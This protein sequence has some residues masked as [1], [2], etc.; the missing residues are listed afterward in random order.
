[1]TY[2]TA[3]ILEAGEF[4]IR[5]HGFQERKYTKEP[6]VAH[7]FRV[8]ETVANV[9]NYDHDEE[10]IIAALL[11][12]TLEDTEATLEQ[13]ED[14]FGFR[15][16][17]MVYEL[18][19][20]PLSVGNRKFR[21][22]VDRSRLGGA[23]APVQTIKCADII[24]NTDSI[25]EHDPGFGKRFVEEVLLLLPWLQRADTKLHAEALKVVLD[26][27]KLLEVHGG[28]RHSAEFTVDNDGVRV[29]VREAYGDTDV[30]C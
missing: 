23:S 19:D 1:M 22:T 25:V 30:G 12:D 11:H 5:A 29:P 13:I 7:C 24:D 15:V 6:Y 21:K 17:F 20:S 14:R 27:A 9:T 16:G 4:A 26:A 2:F 18:T 3:K 10:V 8:A 28:Y